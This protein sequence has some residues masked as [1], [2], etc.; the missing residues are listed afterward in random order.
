[1]KAHP[2]ILKF[3]GVYVSASKS[4]LAL[5]TEYAKEG[6]LR[7]KLK[8]LQDQD[9][10][11]LD[12]HE[13]SNLALQMADGLGYLHVNFIVHRDIKPENFF[14]SDGKIKVA[15]FGHSKIIQD[16]ISDRGTIV[17]RDQKGVEELKQAKKKTISLEFA[18]DVFSFGLVLWEMCS[19]EAPRTAIT[20]EELKYTSRISKIPSEKWKVPPLQNTTPFLAKI[21]SDCLDP[22]PDK[23]PAFAAIKNNIKQQIRKE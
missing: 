13:I 5:V 1:M 16:F 8:K 6:T 7:D 20:D 23:R 3:H 4:K 22:A 12:P 2:H 11:T 21:V 18:V 17:Y 19:G 15:D 9:K 10:K 14:I